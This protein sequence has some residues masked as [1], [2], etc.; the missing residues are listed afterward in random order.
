MRIAVVVG[1]PWRPGD[2][3]DGVGLTHVEVPLAQAAGLA[4]AGA[5]VTVFLDGPAA[6]SRRD[7]PVRVERRASPWPRR[8]DARALRAPHLFAAALAERPDS[9]HLH[10]WLNP[11]QL[12]HAARAPVPVVAE[13]HGGEVPSGALKRRWLGLASTRLSAVVF[14]ARALARPFVDAG[15]LSAAVEVFESPELSAASPPVDHREARRALGMDDGPL[16][17]VVGRVEPPKAPWVTLEALRELAR[18]EPAAR[19]VWATW[20]GRE[21]SA[22]EAALRADP[23]LRH[24]AALRVRVPRAEMS[25]LYAAA[26]AVLHASEREIGGTV[27]F[28]ALSQGAPLSLVDLPTFRAHAPPDAVRFFA[29]GDARGLAEGALEL[30]RRPELRA[31]ARRHFE[32]E[33]SYPAIGRRR[34]ALHRRVAERRRA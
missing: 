3:P 19:F 28:E 14:A 23:L 30:A 34:L 21:L 31:L 5:E 15:A 27:L 8:L 12:T 20:G 6:S 4:A 10:H 1:V 2:D 29:P 33:L 26:S 18:R 7:G 24:R 22:I 9:I 16:F 32:A 25:G 13:H 17:L 11:L